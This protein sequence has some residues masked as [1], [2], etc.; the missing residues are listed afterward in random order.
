MKIKTFVSC[1][2]AIGLLSSGAGYPVSTAESM[3]ITDE[4][5]DLLLE[6]EQLKA[7]N[8][9]LKAEVT[10][11]T[12]KI[13]KMSQASEILL[14]ASDK[15]E[16]CDINGDSSIDAVDASIILQ[17]YA[18]LSTGENIWSISQVVNWDYMKSSGKGVE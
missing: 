17:A 6:N 18:L 10:M 5:A 1:I 11:W 2:C 3:K 8:A 12:D 13:A 16:R 9:Q 4:L 7:E 15:I 14:F